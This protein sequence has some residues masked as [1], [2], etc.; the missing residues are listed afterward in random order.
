MW[1]EEYV[2]TDFGL[3]LRPND[4]LRVGVQVLNLM[5]AYYEESLGSPTA[6][7]MYSVSLAVTP[8]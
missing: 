5:D 1:L 3:Y 2:R 4:D 7:R 6:A 8:F